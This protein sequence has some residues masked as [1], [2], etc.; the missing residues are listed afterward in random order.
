L[1]PCYKRRIISEEV[2]RIIALVGGV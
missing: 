1:L 2:E